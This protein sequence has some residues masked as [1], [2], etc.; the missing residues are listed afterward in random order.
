MGK[1]AFNGSEH[2]QNGGRN[3]SSSESYAEL[4][5]KFLLAASQLAA[6]RAEEGGKKDSAG[7]RY[8]GNPSA[9]ERKLWAGKFK[10]EST[11]RHLR[12]PQT[13]NIVK[14]PTRISHCK[15]MEG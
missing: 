4:T 9:L 8:M 14:M 13:E 3:K 11:L 1:R 7:G 12:K 5:S 2:P 15:G 6:L 10:G